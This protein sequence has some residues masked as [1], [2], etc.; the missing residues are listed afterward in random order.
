MHAA[1]QAPGGVGRGI[2][3]GVVW[4]NTIELLQVVVLSKEREC[5]VE[6]SAPK[7]EMR[8]RGHLGVRGEQ[9]AIYC[10]T[11]LGRFSSLL[12]HPPCEV[13]SIRRKRDPMSPGHAP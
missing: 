1:A 12:L 8:P 10:R 11:S 2:R 13:P 6:V 9:V 7:R 3:G 5:C 4:V